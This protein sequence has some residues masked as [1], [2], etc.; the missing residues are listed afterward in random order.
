MIEFMRDDTLKAMDG[1]I[2]IGENEDGPVYGEGTKEE[3][4]RQVSDIFDEINYQIQQLA[5][6]G[7]AQDNIFHKHG[8]KLDLHEYM[9][10]RA[11]EDAR[12]A[13]EYVSLSDLDDVMEEADNA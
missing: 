10:E 9:E 5:S 2:L 8:L 4:R 6:S 7:R 11:K 3:C 1:M 13:G 12:Y